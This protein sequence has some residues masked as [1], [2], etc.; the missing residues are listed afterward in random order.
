M[1]KAIFL[2]LLMAASVASAQEKKE[3]MADCPFHAKK[4]EVHLMQSGGQIVSNLAFF[5]NIQ[6]F[7]R[8]I[9]LVSIIVRS[10][11]SWII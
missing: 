11:K 10:L 8:L 5:V 7:P 3:S 1:N 2:T 9:V 4:E 6:I